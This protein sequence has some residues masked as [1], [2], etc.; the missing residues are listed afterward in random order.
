M[1]KI[2][3]II[4][5]IALFIISCQ[6]VQ[7][8]STEIKLI[9]V[10][11]DESYGY[12]DQAGK[13]VINPQFLDATIFRD[14]LALVLSHDNSY[15]YINEIGE[16]IIPPTKY[17]DVTPFF[18]GLAWVVKENEAP[19]AINTKGEVKFTLKEAEEVRFFNEDLAAFK[20][21][22]EN[23]IQNWG[24][25]DNTGK[26]IIN[27]QF[28]LV[29]YFNGGLC[30]VANNDGKWG[31]IDKTGKLIINY[32]FDSA[33]DFINNKAV[34]ALGKKT[35]VIDK[36]GKLIINP[37]YD[38]LYIDGD[39]Y[40]IMQNDKY[41]W[42]DKNEIIII[43]PQFDRADPFNG[44]K[45]T[46]V[47]SGDKY[48]YIDTKGKFVINPQFDI[49]LPF[50]GK[51]A[52][53]MNNEKFGFI[54]KDGKYVVNPQFSD[55]SDD[56]LMSILSHSQ[57]LYLEQFYFDFCGVSTDYFDING[58]IDRI[59]KEI[60]ANT[61]NGVGVNTPFDGMK[62]KYSI[63]YEYADQNANNFNIQP[64][65]REKITKEAEFNLYIDSNS[66]MHTF[67]YHIFL[68]G[69]GKYRTASLTKEIEKYL[70]SIGY[71]KDSDE[72]ETYVQ[73]RN[74]IQIISIL[75]KNEYSNIS[76]RIISSE[77]EKKE[78]EGDYGYL[79]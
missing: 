41:G 45:I 11:I 36:T 44:N 26:I 57:K 76:I 61:V 74:N 15:G 28:A 43:N 40:L 58:I 78:K 51:L 7:Q 24:F 14:G 72:T 62:K 38:F 59:K 67:L 16:Y 3:V 31:Y 53:V 20:I 9:P 12:I 32:Q 23:G 18:E 63:E 42:C 6:N 55:I 1:N 21:T 73:F 50:N 69:N 2:S 22:S 71:T 60:T 37:Q 68:L 48:G 33:W 17:K 10:S 46:S 39:N 52:L 30:A 35:G 66:G 56:F 19:T 49:A 8:N 47:A 65:N 54:G 70:M 27:P 5:S 64:I 25:I 75:Q 4:G 29:R 13:F 79:N 77:Q 34:V